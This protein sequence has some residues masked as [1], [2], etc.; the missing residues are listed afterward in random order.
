LRGEEIVI[1]VRNT[2]RWESYESEQRYSLAVALEQEPYAGA[3]IY[4]ELQTT[5]GC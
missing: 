3:S 5:G 2:M 4:G 1:A